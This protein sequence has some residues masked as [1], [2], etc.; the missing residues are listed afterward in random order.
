VQ[1]TSDLNALRAAQLIITVTSAL[2]AIIQPAHL[3]PGA[4]VCDVARPRDVSRAVAEQ[5]DDVLVIEGGM[6]T[7]P[8]NVDF[9]FNFGFPPGMAYAC[10]AETMALALEGRYES[11]TLGKDLTIEQVNTIEQIAQRHGFQLGGFRSFEH[12]VTDEQIERIKRQAY[13]RKAEG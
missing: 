9:H 10:M 3:R 6:V 1:V 8:G 11:Y 5:R 7:V 4:V 12:A 13:S 2:D